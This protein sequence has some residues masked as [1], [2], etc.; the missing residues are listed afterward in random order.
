MQRWQDELTKHPVNTTLKLFQDVLKAAIEIKDPILVIEKTRFAKFTKLFGDTLNRL[1]PDLAPIDLLNQIQSQLQSHGAVNTATNLVS[2]RD[3][4]QFR[5][6]NDQINPSLSYVNQL[7]AAIIGRDTKKSDTEAA[8]VSLEDLMRRISKTGA[9]NDEAVKAALAKIEQSEIRIT[10]LAGNADAAAKAF[11]ESLSAWAKQANETITTSRSQFSELL[12]T[13]Q[14]TSREQLEEFIKKQE[15]DAK[16]KQETLAEQLECVIRDATDKHKKILE[17]YKLVARASITGGHKQIADREYSA[18]QTWRRA[19]IGSIVVTAIWIVYNL[20]WMKHD[21]AVFWLQIAKSV[22]LIA[23]L[24]SF[25]VYA[26]KQSALHRVSERKARSFF[27][28]VQ[29]F[30]PFIENLPEEKQIELKQAL[31]ARIFGPDEREHESAILEHG[32]FKDF[33]VALDLLEKLKKL[34]A[35]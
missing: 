16:L 12:A 17:L 18:A 32:G 8:S 27:L 11:N 24:I 28:Q 23:L 22:S 29:A 33:G 13:T 2:G 26:S 5:T 4:S 3:A 1:D 31:T 6:L 19:T 15:D 10:E 14:S 30:D 34:F 25:A 35:N 7:R 20:F 9:E 21:D